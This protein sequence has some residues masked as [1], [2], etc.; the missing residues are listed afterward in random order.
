MSIERGV[1]G[2]KLDYKYGDE[3]SCFSMASPTESEASSGY[4]SQHVA[5]VNP[6]YACYWLEACD[7]GHELNRCSKWNDELKGHLSRYYSPLGIPTYFGVETDSKLEHNPTGCTTVH[8]LIYTTRPQGRKDIL[9]G[10]NDQHGVLVFPSSKPR[11]RGEPS[12][13]VARRAL[14]WITEETTIMGQGLQSRFVFFD[15]NIIYPLYLT[16]EQTDR[17]IQTFMPSE[18]IRS[19]HW[20]SLEAVLQLLAERRIRIDEAQLGTLRPFMRNLLLYIRKHVPGGFQT[21]LAL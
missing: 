10:L 20:L 19:L 1:K 4:S 5:A 18:Q 11:R 14:E 6:H 2:K 17:L 21:F 13:E 9:L 16:N 7:G 8:V 15:A 3:A 12:M